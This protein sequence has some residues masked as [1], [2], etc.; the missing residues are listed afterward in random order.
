MGRPKAKARNAKG[1]DSWKQSHRLSTELSAAAHGGEL[2][3][4]NARVKHLEKL[5]DR[6]AKQGAAHASAV[7]IELADALLSVGQGP[8]AVLVLR[9]SLDHPLAHHRLAPL[10]L[11]LGP[12]TELEALLAREVSGTLPE[13]S[14]TLPGHQ[15]PTVIRFCTLLLRL[16]AW[17]EGGFGPVREADA[18]L[19]FQEA[20]RAN[21]HLAVLLA[22]PRVRARSC[23][24][25]TLPPTLVEELRELRAAA[26]R[27]ENKAQPDQMSGGITEALLLAT[28]E[29]DGWGTAEWGDEDD[30]M[31]AD[32]MERQVRAWR[33]APLIHNLHRPP[34]PHRPPRPPRPPRPCMGGRAGR[35]L[36]RPGRSI[37]RTTRTPPGSRL[38]YS[39]FCFF[40]V[41]SR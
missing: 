21:W 28:G 39:A 26:S 31:A 22:A 18:S 10:L 34:L 33:S 19:A 9:E 2:A 4:R 27:A 8:R 5:A 32:A 13:V 29:F 37:A 1:N 14:G 11:R 40:N 12:I 23:D 24:R 17:A 35:A 7:R 38:E 6:A 15:P 3:R 25:S 30:E 20:F 41:D 36:A 16:H